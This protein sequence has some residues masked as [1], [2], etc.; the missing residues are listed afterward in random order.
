MGFGAITEYIDVAQITLYVFWL[1]FAGL[2][3]YLRREDTREGYPLE[4]DVGGRIRTPNLLFFPKPKEYALPHGEGSYFAPN[5]DRDTREVEGKRIGP[6]P[7]SPYEPEGDGMGKCIGP[8][9]YAERAKVTDKTIH[10]ENLVAPMRI[11]ENFSVVWPSRDP[12]GMP[13]MGAGGDKAGTVTD[14][15]VD[16]AEQEVRYLEVDIGASTVLLP[17]AFARMELDADRVTVRAIYANQF[18]GVPQLANKD[19]ITR[20]EEEVI[21]AYYGGGYLYADKLRAEPLV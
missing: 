1:F 16:R 13:V 4:A 12:R 2:I 11:A 10:D 21:G 15:W 17:M 5:A 7:G 6:W 20:Y 18:S 14:I 19:E 8:G 9:T 3:I